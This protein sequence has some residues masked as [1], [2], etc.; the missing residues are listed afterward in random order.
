[1]SAATLCRRYCCSAIEEGPRPP[2]RHAPMR[3][4][5]CAM[6]PC[7]RCPHHARLARG[8]VA[9]PARELPL[10]HASR[11]IAAPL[12][13]TAARVGVAQGD[14]FSPRQRAHVVVRPH[15]F[16]KGGQLTNEAHLAGATPDT[17]HGSASP[18]LPVDERD[19]WSAH[20][21]MDRLSLPDQVPILDHLARRAS[22]W[23]NT[24]V[25]NKGGTSPLSP[26]R[27]LQDVGWPAPISR[28]PLS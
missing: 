27:L 18:P 19:D 7:P 17:L 24:F 2:M 8:P 10:P 12:L 9:S 15:G 5:Q 11:V 14:L 6:L 23:N 28:S 13:H 22:C 26:R 20:C 21:W 16:S 4:P 1:M 3:L 25:L